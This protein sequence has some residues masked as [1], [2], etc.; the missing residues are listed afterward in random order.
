[1]ISRFELGKCCIPT[2]IR[3]HEGFLLESENSAQ[4]N[5]L[6]TLGI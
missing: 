6:T 3:R 4:E 5:E 1:M 2:T